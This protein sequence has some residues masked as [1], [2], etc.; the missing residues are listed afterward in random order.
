MKELESFRKSLNKQQTALN[1]ML[2]ASPQYPKAIELFLR[3][4]ALMHSAKMA[5]TETWSFE[6]QVVDDLA[7]EQIRHIPRNGDHSIAWLL[8]HMAR[9]EDVAMNIL[10]A[11]SSQVLH[12]NSWLRRMKVSVRDTGN[13]M[14]EKIVAQLSATIDIKALRAYR[15]AVGRRTREIAKPLEPNELRQKVDP[16]RLQQAL[17][18][19]AVVEA[20]SGLIDYW[21]R[22]TI[23]GLLLMPATRHNIVHWNEALR[24]KQRLSSQKNPM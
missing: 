21:G 2:L 10:V 20:A 14:N 22:R 12:Q 6:D 9:I 17:A 18:E 1:R 15:L 24:I 23:A 11:G 8:W 13:A 5:K 3:Q 4:H 16:R 7:E 19:G